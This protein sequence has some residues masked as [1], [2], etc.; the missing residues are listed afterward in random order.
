MIST[1]TWNMVRFVS[2]AKPRRTIRKSTTTLVSRKIY[3]RDAET[4]KRSLSPMIMA[5]KLLRQLPK[6]LTTS[7]FQFMIPWMAV[8]L[9][10]AELFTDPNTG[11]AQLGSDNKPQV[12]KNGNDA[13]ILDAKGFQ[14]LGTN[15]LQGISKS[16]FA[17]SIQVWPSK[18]T[19]SLK[20]RSIRAT[21]RRLTATQRT[22]PRMAVTWMSTTSTTQRLLISQSPV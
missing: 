13:P 8:S 14:R 21:V 6:P 15:R 19:Q 18:K 4:G 22:Q 10:F 9:V 7:V 1:F 3:Y 5:M 2:T 20:Q 11:L 17:G 12:K 16:G